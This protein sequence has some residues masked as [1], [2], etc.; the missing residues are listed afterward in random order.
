MPARITPLGWLRITVRLAAMLALL[1]ICAALFYVWSFTHRSGRISNPWPR[2]FLAAVARISGARIETV[3]QAPRRGVV[4]L[5]NHV[6]WLDIPILSATTGTAFVA[7]SGLT[8]SPLIGWLCKLNDTVFVARH[9]RRSVHQQVEQVRDAL[10]EMGALT[11]FPEGTTS[12]GTQLLPFKSSLLSSLD[13]PPSGI[14]VQPVWLDYGTDSASIAW[15]G[16]EHGVRNVLRILART[17][18]LSVTVHF[19]AP[20]PPAELGSRKA[21][22]AY[23]QHS[24]ADAIQHARTGNNAA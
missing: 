7:H 8:S 17:R 20:L 5:A 3:G 13:P 12:D 9:D 6:S 14:I 21:I 24:I 2:R 18:P 4:I 19:L 15:V 16:E 11:I 22:A 1:P 23:A 10:S